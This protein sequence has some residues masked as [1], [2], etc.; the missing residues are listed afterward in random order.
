VT[1]TPPSPA[2]PELIAVAHDIGSLHNVGAIF[3][4]ADGAGF[5]RV[6]TSG[7]TGAPPDPRI[8]KVALDA[9]QALAHEAVA[10][11]DALIQRLYGALVVVLEQSPASQSLHDLQL[12]LEYGVREIALVA[13]N[14]LYG[15]P[16]PLLERADVV[17]ELPMRGIKQ[18]LNVS[19]AFGIAAFAVAN[20]VRPFAAE[21][22]RSRTA[23]RGVRAGVLTAGRT[24]GEVPAR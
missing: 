1:T 16:R 6:I 20:A 14:E 7:Y 8:S 18:S 3:R 21:D 22:L 23:P 4:T 5:S 11:V 10:D 15:A 13:C 24:A 9:E 2:A 17:L 19:V 12:E